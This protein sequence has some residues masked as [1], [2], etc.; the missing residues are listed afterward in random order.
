MLRTASSMIENAKK[1]IE[2]M[3]ETGEIIRPI[4]FGEEDS[5]FVTSDDT[6]IRAYDVVEVNGVMYFIGSARN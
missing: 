6:L 4:P 2:T 5:L 1:E 3:K